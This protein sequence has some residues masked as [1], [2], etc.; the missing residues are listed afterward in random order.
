MPVW[1]PLKPTIR[2]PL[3]VL[4]LNHA[5]TLNHHGPSSSVPERWRALYDLNPVAPVLEGLRR[6]L[7][8]GEPPE[9]GPTL[10]A[11]AVALGTVAIALAVFRRAARRFADVL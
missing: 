2:P 1:L 6:V 11:S 4:V 8:E 7:L 5:S 9:P 10:Y 3:F